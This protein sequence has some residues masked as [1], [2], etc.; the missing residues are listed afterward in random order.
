MWADDQSAGASEGDRDSVRIRQR[1]SSRG[2]IC[3]K[4]FDQC[5]LEKMQFVSWP[6]FPPCSGCGYIRFDKH[7]KSGLDKNDATV[8]RC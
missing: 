7:L 4:G 8:F 6:F 1:E 2:D 3:Q 5:V